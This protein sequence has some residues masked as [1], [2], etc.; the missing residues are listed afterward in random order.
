M[1]DLLLPEGVRLV[2]IGPP[3]TA[4]T[5][6]QAAFHA[7]RPALAEHGVHYAGK[8]RHA[9]LAAVQA[10][11]GRGFLGGPTP[12]EDA[13]GTLLSDIHDAGDA[14]VVFSS[15]YLAQAN[16]ARVQRIVE[17]I[18]AKRTHVVLTLRPL[19]KLIPSQWQ[20]YIQ[21]GYD[22]GYEDWLRA[23]FSDEPPKGLTPS[24]WVRHRHDRL[25]ERW[26][27]AVGR[28]N[29]TV[30][31][32]DPRDHG[33]VLRVFEQLVGL[34]AH[35]L[36]LQ[37]DLSNRSLTL[38]EIEVVRAFN[39]RFREK[40]WPDNVHFHYL[41]N[42]VIA[43]MRTR[44]PGPDEAKIVTPAWAQDRI[45]SLTA[46]MVD[47]LRSSGMRILGD[48][49]QLLGRPADPDAPE[50]PASAARVSAKVASLALIGAARQSGDPSVDKARAREWRP[51]RDY[52]GRKIARIVAD[53]LRHRGGA[54]QES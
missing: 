43:E 51:L 33:H 47:N 10:V 4:T 26:A 54:Q 38:A 3:K 18:D 50:Q 35:T 1:S 48:L 16:D 42:G 21:T 22:V 34:P 36:E 27:E 41:R 15:E 7:A 40:K 46:E 14:R 25:A 2:H 53:R 24:F 13:W 45:A 17:E 9:M 37:E 12:A 19:D 28:D 11:G 52:S 29:V 31:V 23:M 6:L 32:L 49:D 30:V 5:S 39:A 44:Q 20:Q 8:G